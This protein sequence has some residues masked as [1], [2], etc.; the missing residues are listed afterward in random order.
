MNL[1]PKLTQSI[2]V[3]LFD[4][5]FVTSPSLHPVTQPKSLL[6]SFFHFVC[7][8]CLFAYAVARNQ[9]LKRLKFSAHLGHNQGE[10][11]QAKM[12][13][14]LHQWVYNPP[15]PDKEAVQSSQIG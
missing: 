13:S 2:H 12:A 8:K 1:N 6:F 10:R 5:I 11:T 4:R 7:G 3:L 14:N 15:F 9:K